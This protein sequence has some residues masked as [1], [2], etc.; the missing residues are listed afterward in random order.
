M[1]QHLS[2]TPILHQIFQL[3]KGLWTLLLPWPYFLHRWLEG[4]ELQE[5]PPGIFDNNHELDTL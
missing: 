3:Q 4:N 5:L 1:R 2:D